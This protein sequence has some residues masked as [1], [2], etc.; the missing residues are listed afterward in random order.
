MYLAKIKIIVQTANWQKIIGKIFSRNFFE[1]FTKTIVQECVSFWWMY[2][3]WR[4]FRQRGKAVKPGQL[5]NF[6]WTC[7]KTSQKLK[8]EM[9]LGKVSLRTVTTVHLRV[10]SRHVFQDIMGKVNKNLWSTL[11]GYIFTTCFKEVPSINQLCS[12][13]LD[14]FYD[15]TKY[16]TNVFIW[17][18]VPATCFK[19]RWGNK[20]EVQLQKRIF[21]RVLRRHKMVTNILVGTSVPELDWR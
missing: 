7:F 15:V 17:G 6:S 1:K 10:F 14:V 18:D 13:V 19:D 9:F 12:T 4:V 3:T 21:G 20:M 16:S 2:F 8:F 11:T 5:R